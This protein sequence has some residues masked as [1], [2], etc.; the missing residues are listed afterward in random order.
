M[1]PF[2]LSS[3]FCIPASASAVKVEGNGGGG[4]ILRSPVA[5][6][7]VLWQGV[8][9]STWLLPLSHQTG[10]CPTDG[11][12]WCPAA[13]REQ[14]EEQYEVER[15]LDVR[16]EPERGCRFYLVKWEGYDGDPME[17]STW[18]PAEA[19]AEF[20]AGAVD[21]FWEEQT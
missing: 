7:R 3:S 2:Q 8:R 12:P 11:K 16:G 18:E 21:D 9:V 13:H 14:T 20:A 1:S 17:E 4:G 6:V 15:I 19:L 10:L 5:Q